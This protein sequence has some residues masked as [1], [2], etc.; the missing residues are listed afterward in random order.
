MVKKPA[1]Y[2]PD[3][4]R[5]SGRPR[6]PASKAAGFDDTMSLNQTTPTKRK[7]TILDPPPTPKKKR[8]HSKAQSLY[9]DIEM[10]LNHSNY[11]LADASQP[12]V[13]AD[14]ND[15]ERSVLG[16]P[17]GELD[18]MYPEISSAHGRVLS[19]GINQEGRYIIPDEIIRF[20]SILQCLQA[21]ETAY[22]ALYDLAQLVSQYIFQHGE[23]RPLIVQDP[24]DPNQDVQAIRN[25]YIRELFR[26]RRDANDIFENGG[27]NLFFT[28]EEWEE[29]V[30]HRVHVKARIQDA[31]YA[32][33]QSQSSPS[34]QFPL[35]PVTPQ[36]G[37]SVLNSTH[38]TFDTPLSPTP[39]PASR[40]RQ[41]ATFS[42]RLAAHK[43]PL[44]PERPK[45]YTDAVT[46]PATCE[47]TRADLQDDLLIMEGV[48]YASLPPLRSGTLVSWNSNAP[49]K[50]LV[51]FSEWRSL[52][53]EANILFII[54]FFK[55][56]H[57][58]NFVN[59]ARIDP[60]EL[61]A[62]NMSSNYIKSALY[63]RNHELAICLFP[64]HV[65]GS[66]ING[67]ARTSTTPPKRF[68]KLEG[69][70]HSQEADRAIGVITMVLGEGDKD[71][72]ADII[73]DVLTFSTRF[74][75]PQQNDPNRVFSPSTSSTSSAPNS[76]TTL[77]LPFDAEIPVYDA[78]SLGGVSPKFDVYTDLPR[79]DAILPRFEGEIPVQSLVVV[80]CSITTILTHKTPRLKANF[81]LRFAI[82][83]GTPVNSA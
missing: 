63:T 33:H 9:D 79:I 60:R 50:G 44:V 42:S 17:F 29:T 51:R 59:L 81:N 41:S 45:R 58:D 28:A 18:L 7:S 4:P 8:S 13:D 48:D 46:L 78:R 30:Q 16:P 20:Q 55:F 19:P 34:T 56:I 22:D 53:D 35:T 23:D 68:R 15:G 65:E 43:L 71:M 25:T 37:K 6:K 1:Q 40:S 64:I 32:S 80:A 76:S 39:T 2:A 5:R 69:L 74:E 75:Q 54:D 73:G 57:H 26:T 77:S 67:F 21:E 66:F 31:R 83:L 49:R 24:D 61:T 11:F 14:E 70:L 38:N 3:P 47:V 12:T 36:K 62:F 27:A 72:A 52:G 10:P 82:L